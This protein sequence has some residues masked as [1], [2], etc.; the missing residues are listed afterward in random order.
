[1]E[2]I[3]FYAVH[4]LLNSVKETVGKNAF[5]VFLTNFYCRF[6]I[7]VSYVKTL[8]TDDRDREE[9]ASSYI[10]K[11]NMFVLTDCNPLV[12]YVSFTGTS[13]FNFALVCFTSFIAGHCSYTFILKTAG[14]KNITALHIFKKTNQSK[15]NVMN[16]TSLCR[17]ILNY[18]FILHKAIFQMACDF[19]IL[20]NFFRIPS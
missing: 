1:M 3:L 14:D 10:V 20:I 12:I 11:Q 19:S 9:E 7:P 5:T 13:P 6:I 4:S 15:L 16:F 2:I 18:H 8:M 17:F